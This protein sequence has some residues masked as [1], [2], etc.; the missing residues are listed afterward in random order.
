[1]S[2][3][4]FCTSYKLTALL[5]DY[6]FKDVCNRANILGRQRSWLPLEQRTALLSVQYNNVSLWDKRQ[7][8]L[9]ATHYKRFGFPKLEILQLWYNQPHVQPSPEPLHHFCGTWRRRENWN[10]YK[11]HILGVQRVRKSFLSDL[12]V[13]YLLPVFMKL[14]QD[15]L[16]AC[17]QGKIS[18]PSQFL[19]GFANKNTMQKMISLSEKERW[20]LTEQLTGFKKVYWSWH[21]VCWSNCHRQL[22]NKWSSI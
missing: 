19:P 6:L 11:T 10:K 1:M 22:S 12:W 13:S 17:K 18:D 15:N 14:W 7:A 4:C 2:L 21:Q 5:L 8:D 16:L 9:L 20:G 3:L